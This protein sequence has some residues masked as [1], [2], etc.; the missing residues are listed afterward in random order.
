MSALGYLTTTGGGASGVTAGVG[1]WQGGRL[2]VYSTSGNVSLS[3]VSGRGDVQVRTLSGAVHVAL[4]ADRGMSYG[5]ASRPTAEVG[6]AHA[7]R[8]PAL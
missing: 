4:P 2:L 5:A 8:P 1:Q 3:H 7:Q 6:H